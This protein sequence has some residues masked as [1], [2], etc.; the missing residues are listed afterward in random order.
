MTDPSRSLDERLRKHPHFRDR[1]HD[2]A[3]QHN[4][5]NLQNHKTAPTHPYDKTHLQ[6]LQNFTHKPE[7]NQQ[8]KIQFR[9]AEIML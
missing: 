4:L 5:Q 2:M 1:V 3:V 9:P 7:Q 6:S 8:K